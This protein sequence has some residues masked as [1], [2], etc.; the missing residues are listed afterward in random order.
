MCV[1]CQ[2]CEAVGKLFADLWERLV[3]FHQAVNGFS[4]G[5]SDGGQTATRRVSRAIHTA[6]HVTDEME[7]AIG[8]R[9]AKAWLGRDLVC[10]MEDEKQVLQAI[11]DEDKL[12]KLD[13]LLLQLTAK[14]SSYDCVTCS[15]APKL[16]ST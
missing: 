10:V 8:F 13:G 4:I 14:S 12:K 9:P 15:F 6:I 3:F 1:N 2:D 11:P 16:N 5:T 7:Q